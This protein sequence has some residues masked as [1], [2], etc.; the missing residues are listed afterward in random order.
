MDCESEA[1]SSGLLTESQYQW[2]SSNLKKSFDTSS[3]VY[4]K[5]VKV[6]NPWKGQQHDAPYCFTSSGQGTAAGYLESG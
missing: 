5:C 3:W 2:K 6:H 4:M 1:L